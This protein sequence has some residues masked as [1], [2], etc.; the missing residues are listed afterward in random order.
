[1]ASKKI[2]LLVVAVVAAGIFGLPSTV[3]LFS[4][5]H[6]WYYLGAGGNDVPCEKCHSDIADEMDAFVG[7]HTGETGYGKFECGYCHRISELYTYAS[8]Y[9]TGS[10]PGKEAHAA[11]AIPCMH[12]HSG[13]GAH[14]EAFTNEDCLKCHNMVIADVDAGGFG[15][16]ENASDTGEK[17]A[18]MKFVLDAMNNSLMEGANE[19]CIACHTR[20]GVNITWTKNEYLD[21]TAEE[22]AAGNWTIPGFTAG[23]ENVTQVNTSNAWTNP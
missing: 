16:G 13:K 11:S 1:M 4:G 15:L 17:A 6:S 10:I 21:F 8:G 9:G 20:I 5:Q 14:G 12:C 19:A 2:V 22:D 23:G 7:P 18:H 3:S